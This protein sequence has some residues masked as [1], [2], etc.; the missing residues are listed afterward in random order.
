MKKGDSVVVVK[1][2]YN[3]TSSRMLIVKNGVLIK[4][5]TGLL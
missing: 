4:A 5:H 2:D 1:N 3:D